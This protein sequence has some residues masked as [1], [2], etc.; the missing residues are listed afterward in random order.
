[1]KRNHVLAVI[2][3]LGCISL[4]ASVVFRT[5]ASNENRAIQEKEELR[6]FLSGPVT[7]H[8]AGRANPWVSL[9]DGQ[10]ADI[11]YVGPPELLDPLNG[12]QNRPLSIASVDLD[13]DGVPDIV[14]GYAGIQD[15][16]ITVQRGDVDSIFPN[17][18]DAIAHRARLSESAGQ[19]S[20]KTDTPSPFLVQSKVFS[21]QRAP[22]FLITGDFDGDGHKDVITAEEGS[23]AL[24]LLPGDGHGNF[25]TGHSIELPGAVTAL[26]AADVNRMDGLADIVVAVKSGGNAKLLVYEGSLGAAKASPE[27]INLSAECNSIAT[28]QLDEKFPIDIA[29]AAGNE[30]L[31]VH[32]RDRKHASIDGGQLDLLPP[33]VTRIPVSVPVV[34]LAVGDFASDLQHEIAVLSEDGV[35]RVFSRANADGSVWQPASA[36]TLPTAK[37]LAVAAARVLLS[38]RVSGSTTDDLLVLDPSAHQLHIIINASAMSPDD[39]SSKGR[40][41]WQLQIAGVV[42][43]ESEPTALLGMRLNSDALNDLVVLRISS[44]APT[45]ILSSPSMTFSVTN[46]NDA[47]AGSLRQAI[48]NANSNPGPDAISFAIPGTGIQTI[49]L[50]SSLPAISAAVTIDG[51]TQNPGSSSPSIELSGTSAGVGANGFTIAGGGTTVRGFVINACGG[52]GIDLAGGGSIIEGN[53]IGTS[54]SGGSGTGNNDKGVAIGSGSGH[55]IGGTTAAARNVISGNSGP[56][57]LVLGPTMNNLVQGN[58]IG[59]DATGVIALGNQSDGVEM[60]SGTNNVINCTVGGT[61]AGARN[62]ISANAGVGVQFITVGTSNLIQGNLIGTDVSGTNDLGNGSSGVAINE[63]NDCTVG[64]TVPGAGNVI[65]G[66]GSSGV[67]I[68]AVSATGNKVQGNKIGTD[69]NGVTPIPNSFDGILVFNSASNN[70][71]GGISGEGNII[72]FNLGAGILVDS[73]TGNLIQSNSIFSNGTLGIDL[74]PL[75]VTPNDPGDPD[76]GA[77]ALQNFPVLTFANG[78]IGGGSNV[79]GT[80]NSTANSTFTLNFFSNPACDASGNG[81]GKSFLGSAVTTTNGSGN[82]TFNVNVSGS[83]LV[84][85]SITATATSAS[86]NTSEFSGCIVYGAAD[87]SVVKVASS[88]TIVVGSNVTYTITVSNNGPDAANSITLTDNLPASL[89]FVSCSSTGGGVCGGSGNNRVITFA[90]LASGSSAV[91]TIVAT[92]NCSVTNGQTVTNTALVTSVVRDPIAG[93]NSSSVDFTVSNP[94][95]MIS[96]TSASYAANGGSGTI[97]VTAPAGCGWQAISNDSWLTITSGSGGIG[98]GVASYNVATNN[99]GSPRTGTM[100]VAGIT[101]TVNQ[102]NISCQ[103]SISPTSNSFGGDGGSGTVAL[104]TQGGCQWK[105]ISNDSWLT[106]APESGTGTGSGSFDYSVAPNP[107][108]TPRTGTI[109]V[110]TE[111]FTVMQDSAGGCQFVIE[112]TGKLFTQFGSE[113][114]FAMTTEA[115]CEWNTSTN[116]SWILITSPQSSTGSGTVTYAVRDNMT[117]VPRQGSIMAGGQSFTVV[118]DGG[119]LSDC[120]YVLTPS[121]AVFNASGGNGSIQVNTEERCAWDATV[122]VNWISFTSQIV[123]IGT[124]T[125]TYHVNANPSAGGRAGL[126]TIAGKTF[127]VK[128]KGT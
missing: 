16:L 26:I 40:A 38:A 28:G 43:F 86:G 54:A 112:P 76:S 100:T 23:A 89:S 61:T 114:S 49:S 75:G 71:I 108:P 59:I 111:T 5:R 8:A 70:T 79:Q 88:G 36:V 85:D 35:C 6:G 33:V 127:K 55:T 14:S 52:G 37:N 65:S 41:S 120:V 25:T 56:G 116:D 48:Q 7:A 73:G 24:W 21:V 118:Q 22:Q 68:N 115:S 13:E 50:L 27:V 57:V 29:A 9:R 110:A 44:S 51:T 91:T 109:T 15:N 17:T 92:L 105:A 60:L 66:N 53:Y 113:S 19:S 83:A 69:A 67:R 46:T 90:S 84:G 4:P 98:N 62:V 122:N 11:Q 34:S 12:N 123:G 18:R 103:Y 78:A 87:L 101:F 126:I 32:G 31:I 72:A 81:E 93:N 58:F 128:Q 20:L 63:A 97:S 82:A 2:S 1:M 96:P 3:I 106:V 121:S 99:T 45:V 47:G 77:N 64:G 125:V 30:V 39:S 10:T 94:P 104:T 107:L 80:L 124:R 42:D 117:G 102:S 95:R 74:A 119:T